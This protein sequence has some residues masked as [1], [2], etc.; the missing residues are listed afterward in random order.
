MENG[1]NDWAIRK[2]SAVLADTLPVDKATFLLCSIIPL[3]Y[4]EMSYAENLVVVD[5]AD[6][7]K[8]TNVV[9]EGCDLLVSMGYAKWVVNHTD[10]NK[11]DPTKGADKLA[12]GY[13]PN[14]VRC[15]Y[16]IE[17]NNIS[18]SVPKIADTPKNLTYDFSTTIDKLDEFMDRYKVYCTKVRLAGKPDKI[19]KKI[20]EVLTKVQTTGTITST[21]LLTYL[22]CVTAMVYEWTDVPNSYRNPKEL[23]TA[24]KVVGMTTADKLIEV[25]PYFVENYP[26]WAKDGYESVNI[27]TFGIHFKTAILKMNG[28]TKTNKKVN[29]ENDNL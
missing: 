1:F 21:D 14:F 27:F 29:I 22:D 24:K 25:V 12:I 17:K 5:V 26:N 28:I 7:R 4:V 23:A 13:S 16:Y 20:K 11:N 6:I 9:K 15:I 2:W 10:P 18:N 3:S 19:Y 8:Y